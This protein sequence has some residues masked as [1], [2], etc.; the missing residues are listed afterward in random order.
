VYHFDLGLLRALQMEQ[1]GENAQH[2]GDFGGPIRP[3][4]IRFGVEGERVSGLQMALVQNGELLEVDGSFGVA[5]ER[6]LMAFQ[7]RHALE[8]DGIAG[9]ETLRALRM[10]S[11]G[12]PLGGCEPPR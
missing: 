6:A 11:T 4:P 10:A 1:L 2:D 7:Q 3:L 8:T 5:T 12:Q 9:P